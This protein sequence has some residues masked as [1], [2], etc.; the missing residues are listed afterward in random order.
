MRHIFLHDKLSFLLKFFSIKT[1]YLLFFVTFAQ[2]C[3]LLSS[4][5]L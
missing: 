4:H 1:P 2:T 3:V 5:E